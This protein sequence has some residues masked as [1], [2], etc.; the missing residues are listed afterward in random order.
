VED[1][2]RSYERLEFVGDGVLGL[3][4]AEHLYHRFP[5]WPEGELARTRQVVVSR[6]SCA[7]VA[8]RLGLV[9]ELIAEG[10]RRGVDDL[11]GPTRSRSVAAALVEAAIGA[12]FL[13]FG[14]ERAARAVVEA[15]ANEVEYA[16]DAHVDYKTVL[17]E[18]LARRGASV[19][20]ALVETSGPPHRR[21][22]TTQAIV[23][24]RALGTGSGASKKASEQAAAREALDQLDELA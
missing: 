12:V 10:Q 23:G 15:F 16:V 6:E 8:R 17:Q 21:R 19:T 7:K 9:E 13:S 22:F 2:G 11:A 5:D 18:A 3:A 24:D 1:R 14:H 4:V 20:Y